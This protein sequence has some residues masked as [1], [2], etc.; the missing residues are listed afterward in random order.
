MAEAI[1]RHLAPGRLRA[2]SAGERIRQPVSRPALDC[3]HA[4]GIST[5]GLHSKLWGS[6]FGLGREPVRFLVALDDVYAARAAWPPETLISHWPMS[7]PAATDESGRESGEVFEKA[8]GILL[9]RVQ[10]FVALPFDRLD[11]RSLVEEIA[12]IGDAR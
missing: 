6:F 3:L 12:R 1:L 11:E 7:D 5:T 2:A 9:A 10:R 4:H 8:F